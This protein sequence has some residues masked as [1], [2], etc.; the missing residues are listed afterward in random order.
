MDNLNY[1]NVLNVIECLNVIDLG[2]FAA[3]SK[4]YLYLVEEYRRLRGPEV[5]TFSSWDRLTFQQRPSAL[6]A[7]APIQK[8]QKPPNLV[9]AFNTQRSTIKEELPKNLPPNT[10]ILGACAH[11]I[12][13]NIGAENVESQ[14]NASVMY[15]SFPDADIRA[16]SFDRERGFDVDLN[17][18]EQFSSFANE[19]ALKNHPD[20]WK[21]IIV[22]AVGTCSGMAESFVLAI[23]SK[24]PNVA[25]VG[26]ICNDGY[27][28]T[29][30]PQSS[31]SELETLTV[32][33]LR[34]RIRMLGGDPDFRFV[35][36][37]ELVDLA[38]RLHGS[39]SRVT[40]DH[41]ED[42][43]FGVVLGGD[44]PVRSMVS[45][46]VKSATHKTPQ[47]S[48][49]YV[50]NSVSMMRPDDEHFIFRGSDMQAVHMIHTILDKETGATIPAMDLLSRDMNQA[51]F[52][53]MKR[54][55]EDG[56]ELY[57]LSPY[58]QAVNALMI[59]TDGSERQQET[60]EGA[61]LDFFLLDGEACC[62]DM[63]HTVN[64]LRDQTRDEEILG[65]LMYSCAGRGPHPG[66][67]I[68]ESMADATR[69]ARVYP[70][71]PCL[72]FYAGGEIGPIALVGNQ[73]V[74][75]KGKAAVQG[76]TAVFCLFIVPVVG[77][78][79]YL[80]DDSPD[81]VQVFVKELLSKR[82]KPT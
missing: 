66:A 23:Q 62:Q 10:I 51:D 63:D 58:S 21:A 12:Q 82:S 52:V 69:F 67:L 77:R 39:K 71:V 18:K 75:R 53:G 49:K 70:E 61:E 59:M 2:Q 34:L 79:N 14:S 27:I 28:T 32:R 6:V 55:Q 26:G 43:L 38:F 36:K 15:A 50:V 31:R 3:A 45:R 9:L 78:R 35:E 54:P 41:V 72:G 33:Q 16:F 80:L 74:F 46:G 22:Y 20:H 5:V 47:S 7:S 68:R 8:L 65:A 1:N 13:V 37:S 81:S 24:L 4:R 73:N 30:S 48:S 11:S 60:L 57:L 64:M 17:V 19:L 44:V 56:F 42:G 25:I 40:L 76:F 29:E